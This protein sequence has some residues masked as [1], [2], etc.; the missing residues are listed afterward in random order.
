[1]RAENI[2]PRGGFAPSLK[3]QRQSLRVASTDLM[4]PI[5]ID[6]GDRP[7]EEE[8]GHGGFDQRLLDNIDSVQIIKSSCLD[9]SSGKH[10]NDDEYSSDDHCHDLYSSKQHEGS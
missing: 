7:E 4:I 3:I 8:K 10:S 2:L 1:M 6:D 5:H 9:D